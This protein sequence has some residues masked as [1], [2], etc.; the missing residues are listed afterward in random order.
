MI[1][2]GKIWTDHAMI[3]WE[4]RMTTFVLS[5]NM[6]VNLYYATDVHP[7]FIRH[8]LVWMYVNCFSFQL[9]QSTVISVY[10]FL[11]PICGYCNSLLS[12]KITGL[13]FVWFSSTCVGYPSWWLVLPIMLLCD[14]Q[15]NQNRRVWE[16]TFSYLHSMWT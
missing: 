12:Y 4:E 9:C 3:C 7:H 6:V 14:L 16:C 11:F 2:Q 15:P 5:V 13:A 10:Y 1:E 8:V